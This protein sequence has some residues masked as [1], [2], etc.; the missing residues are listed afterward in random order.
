MLQNVDVSCHISIVG[1]ANAQM[2]TST[3]IK[4]KLLVNV[5]ER[6][7]AIDRALKRPDQITK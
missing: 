2:L 1:P 6:N 7:L 4:D 5:D 3:E